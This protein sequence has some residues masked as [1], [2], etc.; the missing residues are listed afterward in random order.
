MYNQ[1]VLDHFEMGERY[2]M[3]YIYYNTGEDAKRNWHGSPLYYEYPNVFID[4]L[5]HDFFGILADEE[6]DLLIA[7][8]CTD[9][10]KVLMESF[11]ISYK[12]SQNNF[13]LTNISCKNMNVKIDL[14]KMINN[15]KCENITLKPNESYAYKG[16]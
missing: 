11:G 6:S 7:P 3:N 15:F 8:C 16:K 13:I 12:Y 4:V 5:I 1:A 9:N 10:S 14:S 2:D